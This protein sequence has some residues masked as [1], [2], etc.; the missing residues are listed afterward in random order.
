MTE[1]AP[2]SA[3]PLSLAAAPPPL[4]AAAPRRRE[5]AASPRTWRERLMV[6]WVGYFPLTWAVG[7]AFVFWPVAALL[8]VGSLRR[9]LPWPAATALLMAGALALSVVVGVAAGLGSPA[10]VLG[11]ATNISVWVAVAGIIAA[12]ASRGMG[13]DFLR[14][15]VWVGLAN[16][17]AAVIGWLLGSHASPL[18]LLHGLQ[19]SA[20]EPARVWLDNLLA[21]Q[22]WFGG[23]VVR[24]AGMMAYPTWQGAVSAASLLLAIALWQRRDIA[25]RWVLVAQIAT[26]A[27]GVYVSY[28]RVV[29]MGLAVALA[30]W[31]V[32]ALSQRMPGV[33]LFTG[34]LAVG[35]AVTAYALRDHVASLLASLDENRP[36]SS[37][38]RESIYADTLA[39]MRTHPFPLLGYGIKATREGSE[40]NIA[41]HSTYVG[42]YYRGG[43]LA[44]GALAVFLL[45]PVV[46]A[47]RHRSA[48]VAAMAT[49]PLVP[50]AFQDYDPGHLLPLYTV[51]VFALV[52]LASPRPPR[53]AR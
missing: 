27:F 10:R 11:A 18:P 43:L 6:R 36:G 14:A 42:I 32:V 41:T 51:A 50:L 48:A 34:L 5:R 40:I 3:V 30:V 45:G 25:R 53:S 23:P 17:S 28:S 38:T 20:P 4:A 39:L 33:W 44:V 12:V 9:R 8:S 19:Y 52:P 16:S 35:V 49:F 7:L 13:D 24:S 37:Q 26:A 29:W 31:L 2:E 47:L 21:E 46:H 15:L 22:A 1:D